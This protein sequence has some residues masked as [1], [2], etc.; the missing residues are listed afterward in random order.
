VALKQ[1][2]LAGDQ[3]EK[4]MRLLRNSSEIKLDLLLTVTGV[5]SADT[6]DSVYHLW[7]YSHLDQLVIKVLLKKADV[8][9]VICQ[10]YQASLISG[11]QQTGTSVRPTI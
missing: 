11:Q 4:A 1:L 2:S 5:D 7:S 10:R 9:K 6:F 8:P 3:L